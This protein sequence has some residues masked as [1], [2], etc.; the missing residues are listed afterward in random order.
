MDS[1]F[2]DI[3][4]RYLATGGPL[5]NRFFQVF[6]QSFHG[7]GV[8]PVGFPI[9]NPVH[10]IRVQPGFSAALH[11]GKPWSIDSRFDFLERHFLCL[12]VHKVVYKTDSIC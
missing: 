2:S 12:F 6:R 8:W 10:G 3:V 1:D 7:Q 9:L 5:R 11:H 4:T